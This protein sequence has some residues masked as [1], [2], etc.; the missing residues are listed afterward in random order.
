MITITIA[1]GARTHTWSLSDDVEYSLEQ[2]RVSIL[3]ESQITETG[4]HGEE[5][6]RITHTPRYADIAEMIVAHL[7]DQMIQPAVDIFPPPSLSQTRAAV[8]AARD[9]LATATR[10]LL[11][12]PVVTQQE[13]TP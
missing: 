7:R 13:R 11:S 9:A 5:I 2:Q 4:P 8:M 3:T 10:S 12:S 1:I 6:R